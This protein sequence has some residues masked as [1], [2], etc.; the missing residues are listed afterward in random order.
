M[1]IRVRVFIIYPLGRDTIC[2]TNERQWMWINIMISSR[3]NLFFDFLNLK[4]LHSRFP[5]REAR[6]SEYG[7][8]S[9]TNARGNPSIPYL[10][11]CALHDARSQ[12]CYVNN[13]TEKFTRL[14]SENVYKWV[15]CK[16]LRWNR[17]LW[18]Y[19]FKTQFD[20]SN[21]VREN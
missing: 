21:V 5:Q 7:V 10:L 2:R 13:C 1:I 9:A 16:Y 3:Y 4:K 15:I 18:R 12:W 20:K 17:L 6:A 14:N 8:F 19:V 11:L